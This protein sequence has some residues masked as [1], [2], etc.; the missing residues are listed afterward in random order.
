MQKIIVMLLCIIN[1]TCFAMDEDPKNYTNL[2]YKLNTADCYE[3]TCIRQPIF[4]R[5]IIFSYGAGESHAKEKNAA[6]LKTEF[7]KLFINLD[8]NKKLRS[9]SP[10][11][12]AQLIQMGAD[13][14]YIDSLSTSPLEDAIMF[15]EIDKV[16]VL[17]DYGANL[18]HQNKFGQTP[19][20]KVLELINNWRRSMEL[21]KCG[22]YTFV[23]D[24]WTAFEALQNLE[25]IKIII[26]EAM[27]NNVSSK[28]ESV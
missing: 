2:K 24:E 17:I 8:I 4:L 7:A 1:A 20:D 26:E 15:R 27:Q 5:P 19:L 21:M 22:I 16:K 23:Q 18:Y 13:V 14:N 9:A 3:S 11:E 25:A 12:A 10:Q 6:W 28:A